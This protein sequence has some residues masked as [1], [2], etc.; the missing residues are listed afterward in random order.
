VI[1]HADESPFTVLTLGNALGSIDSAPFWIEDQPKIAGIS[2]GAVVQVIGEVTGYRDRRQ[3]KVSSIRVL[4]RATVDWELLVPG[5]GDPEPWWDALDKW[6]GDVSAPRLRAVLALFFQDEAFRN[7]FAAAPA[8][9]SGAHARRGGLLKLTAEVVA[10]ARPLARIA[11]CDLDLVVAGALLH[12]IG[13]T[14]CYTDAWPVGLTERGSLSTPALAGARLLETRV[15][16]GTPPP[17]GDRE[18]LILQ[19]IVLGADDGS[20]VTPLLVESEAVRL[21]VASSRGIVELADAAR[22]ATP[23]SARPEE[24]PLR[25]EGSRLFWGA[26]PDWG[27]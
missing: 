16:A 10:A 12:G 22:R 4:P 3:L 25:R 21:A 19:H 17:V 11:G 18:L 5:V 8:G 13:Y 6:R 15:H 23:L 27:R 26:P 7:R 24:A 2:R 20:P 1:R 9:P 14:E